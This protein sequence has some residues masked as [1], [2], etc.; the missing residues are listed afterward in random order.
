MKKLIVILMFALVASTVSTANAQID[1]LYIHDE[2]F[3]LDENWFLGEDGYWYVAIPL[4]CTDSLVVYDTETAG[5]YDPQLQTWISGKSIMITEETQGLRWVHQ[6]YDNPNN[7]TLFIGQLATTPEETKVSF[8]REVPLEPCGTEIFAYDLINGEENPRLSCLWDDGETSYSRIVYDDGTYTV[9]VSDSCGRQ[10]TNTWF[11]G[12]W[13]GTHE[14]VSS[15]TSIYPNPA[16]GV[17]TVRGKGTLV[18]FNSIG[19]KVRESKI[20]NETII[21]GLPAGMY[22][23]QVGGNVPQKVVVVE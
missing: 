19:Q 7:T 16:H 21:D 6:P 3:N 14:T 17:F 4:R 8:E 9:T 15:A 22:F 12:D 13:T 1:S 18:I 2:L 23:V 10:V 5:W 20:N 11:V